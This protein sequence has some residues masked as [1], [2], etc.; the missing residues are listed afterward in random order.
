MVQVSCAKLEQRNWSRVAIGSYQDTNGETRP[1]FI[2]QYIDKAGGSH[3]DH[4]NYE[5]QG[6]SVATKLLGDVATVPAIRFRSEE[7]L[8]N[9][10][11]FVEIVSLDKL[12][13]QDEAAF[14]LCIDSVLKQMS[15]VL[16]ALQNPRRHD[17]LEIDKTKPRAWGGEPTAA[18]F[19]GFDI[20]NA[21]VPAAAPAS[22]GDNQLV[23][24]DFIRPYYAPIEEAAAKLFVS[25]GLLNWGKPLHR[26]I[27][28]PD[29][30]LLE[31]SMPVLQ[32]WL[33]RDAVFAELE[34]QQKF[35]PA[36]F[37]DDKGLQAALKRVGGGVLA[38]IYL[39]R[40]RKWC[41]RNLK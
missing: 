3:P 40:L 17:G 30:A 29:H 4:W 37:H 8:L 39:L 7:F 14:D 34:L 15:L 16:T 12:L 27:K 35:R 20:R 9:V 24:F 11:D 22:I 2:K 19:K 25:L 32:P 1:C 21:G 36:K 26:S 6:V 23:L 5:R 18:N 10:F 28:G 38:R 13:R 33:H 31:R 41:E